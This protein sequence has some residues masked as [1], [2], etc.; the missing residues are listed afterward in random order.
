MPRVSVIMRTKDRD[1]L[2]RRALSDVARQT[3]TDWGLVIVNDGGSASVVDDALAES[4]FD[5]AKVQ[6]IHNPTS[7]GM[8]AASNQGLDA[9]ASE[10]VVVHD[11]DDTWAEDFL[12]VTVGFLD[13][14][15][16]APGVTVRTEIVFEEEQ[17]GRYVEV[18]REPFWGHLT[19]ISYYDLLQINRFVPISFL[20][21]RSVHDAVG[22]FREDLPVVGDWDFHLRIARRW[23]IPMLPE[24]PLAFWHHR[25]GVEGV[26]GN[27]IYAEADA[28]VAWDK[29]VRDEAL[30]SQTPD[31]Q[32]LYTA[33]A[34][35]ELTDELRGRLNGLDH[36]LARLDR[37]DEAAARLERVEAAVARL[38]RLDEALV[39]LE[40]WE[41]AAARLE[42]QA[43]ANQDQ[44]RE[45]GVIALLRRKYWRARQR[46]G[47]DS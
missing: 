2:L 28:H 37:F 20:Y 40:R 18:G 43:R 42:E 30:R 27:S 36:A 8:E 13:E 12:A 4:G 6:V 11:D 35:K 10:F 3:F 47:G 25:R 41:Q 29:W 15:P 31:A 7:H 26:S 23:N 46:L 21:R 14:H 5:P 1:V 17:D 34:I 33:R 16:D 19:S 22:R 9:G 45:L 38:D 44:I 24:R 39:R 32:A